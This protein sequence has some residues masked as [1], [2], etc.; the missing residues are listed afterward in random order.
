M[1]FLESRLNFK[2]EVS[3]RIAGMIEKI[4]TF[5]KCL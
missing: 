5:G 3:H 1:V 2:H 4:M